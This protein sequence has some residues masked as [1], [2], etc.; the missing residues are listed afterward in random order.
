MLATAR[1]PLIRRVPPGVWTG[2]IWCLPT[3]E[4]VRGYFGIPGMPQG[5]APLPAWSW[6]GLISAT[7]LALAGAR[8]LHRR[9]LEALGLLIA[10][11]FLAAL[12]MSAQGI[13][14]LHFVA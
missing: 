10:G 6:L 4:S 9:P 12:A 7:I 1:P 13:A 8:V 5:Q 3:A 14:V 2:V 11:S